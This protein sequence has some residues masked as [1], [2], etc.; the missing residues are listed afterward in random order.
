MTLHRFS[1]K[2]K[3]GEKIRKFPKPCR[4]CG[5]LS[6]EPLCEPHA[7]QAKQIHEA[8]R[9]I[10]KKETGQYGGDYQRRAK[11]VRESAI[12]CHLCGEGRRVDDPWE[13]DHVEPSTQGSLARLL[14]AHRTCNRSKSNKTNERNN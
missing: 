5:V 12:T 1:S 9:A 4:I 6:L 3:V 2:A 11:A 7:L 13:A 14:P 10:R 8:R